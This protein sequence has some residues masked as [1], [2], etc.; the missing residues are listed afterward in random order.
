MGILSQGKK[1][2]PSAAVKTLYLRE[3]KKNPLFFACVTRQV[4][5]L[6]QDMP[7]LMLGGARDEV[8]PRSQMRE[9]WTI[10]RSRGREAAAA[11]GRKKPRMLSGSTSGTGTGTGGPEKVRGYAEVVDEDDEP[12]PDDPKV[13]PRVFKDGVNTYFE[14]G[15]G[16]HSMSWV[17]LFL[18]VFAENFLCCY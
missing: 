18:C 2:S 11:E 14:F 16:R 4:P 13:P 15:A 7:V 3:F 1:K 10:I 12:G 8:V 5:K 17:F 9:L 6:P